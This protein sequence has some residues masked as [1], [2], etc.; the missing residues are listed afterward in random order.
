MT[1]DASQSSDTSASNI[2]YERIFTNSQIQDLE[3]QIKYLQQKQKE[4]KTHAKE[5][6]KKIQLRLEKEIMDAQQSGNDTLAKTIES[7]VEA[8]NTLSKIQEEEIDM[9][10]QMLQEQCDH[11][12][13][14]R[15]EKDYW[16]E[17]ELKGVI[18][19]GEQPTFA[20]FC[21][22]CDKNFELAQ[23]HLDKKLRLVRRLIDGEQFGEIVQVLSLL[24]DNIDDEEPPVT[25]RE[26]QKDNE[27]VCFK[28]CFYGT[29]VTVDSKGQN[30]LHQDTK[31]ESENGYSWTT[32]L[33]QPDDKISLRTSTGKYFSANE[34]GAIDQVDE[35]TS[36]KEQFTMIVDDDDDVDKY[37]FKTSFGRY[38]SANDK[39][40]V[41]QA[42]QCNES[43]W[44]WK[45]LDTMS[46][47]DEP[48]PPKKEEEEVVVQAEEE[49]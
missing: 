28:S 48:V 43:E 4:I 12:A 26:P 20:E 24:Q 32:I 40:K 1:T 8:C 19:E 14:L 29:Y 25:P 3:H 49:D 11:L 16:K 5:E 34:S 9:D 45:I 22:D 39:G 6:F 46:K 35:I 27:E 7:A 17:L 42:I 36:E 37:A 47:E 23:A 44:F 30:I 38:I 2:H 31:D 18:G 13:N 15:Y 10:Y 21:K 41:V 33:L